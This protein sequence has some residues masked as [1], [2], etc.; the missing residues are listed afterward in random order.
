MCAIKRL[1]VFKEAI[2]LKTSLSNQAPFKLKN[3]KIYNLLN[4]MCKKLILSNQAPFRLKNC[5]IYILLDIYIYI[6]MYAHTH[7]ARPC[8]FPFIEPQKTSQF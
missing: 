1:N 2:Y 8:S 6:Y 4:S 7:T 5:K 3:C